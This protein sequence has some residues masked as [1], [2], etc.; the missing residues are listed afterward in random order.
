MK[1][2]TKVN[3]IFEIPLLYQAHMED[4][5]DV[6][7]LIKSKNQQQLL[8]QRNAD[9]SKQLLKINSTNI[10]KEED[11]DFIINNDSDINNL[12]NQIKDI[13]NKL[14]SRLGQ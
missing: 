1:K 2:S 6:I 11:A 7:I 9:T 5:F 10:I 4:I 12:K 8:N 13:I 3:N 14:K